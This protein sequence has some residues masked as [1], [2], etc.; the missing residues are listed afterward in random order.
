MRLVFFGSGAFGLPTLEALASRHD[1]L[2]VVSQPDRPAGRGGKPT[3]TPVTDWALAHAPRVPLLRT[4]RVNDPATAQM[5]RSLDA[6]AWVVIAFG[7]KLGRT[8]LEGVFA[9]NLHASRLPRWRGAAPIHAAILAGDSSTGNSVITLADRMDAG[10]VLGQ[11]ERRIDPAQTAGELHDLLA[12]DG[13]ALVLDVLEKRRAGT[14][15]PAPQDESLATLAPK[16]GKSDAWVDLSR[17]AD[18][19][20]RRVHGLT[21]W[22]GVA[23]AFRGEAL[24]LLRVQP[25]PGI[26]D[27]AVVGTLTDAAAGRV[28]CGESGRERLRLLEVQAAGKRG[29]P[30]EVFARGQRVTAGERLRGIETC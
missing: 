24:K 16:L 19:C 8:L 2:A 11:T 7:Q 26:H 6:D 13:P 29:L 12:M 18:E 10:D 14:L 21:P 3:P 27:Q 28:A 22:P 20:R 4:D 25:E 15:V 30:W 1:L 17:P 9:A 23:V 5:L